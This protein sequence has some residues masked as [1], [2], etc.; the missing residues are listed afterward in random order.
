MLV[1]VRLVVCALG[2]VALQSAMGQKAEPNTQPYVHRNTFGVFTEYSN[3]SSHMLMGVAENRK[4][5][6]LGG[7]YAFRVLSTRF[8]TLQYLGEIR[9]VMYT[10]DPVQVTT[11][12]FATPAGIGPFVSSYAIT[13][14]C[15]AQAEFFR[16]GPITPIESGTIT[17][18]C[19][20]R[21]TYATGMNP[22][23]FKVNLMPHH[24]LQPIISGGLGYMFSTQPI[25]IPQAGSFNFAFEFGGGL[26]LFRAHGRAMTLEYH[27]HHYSNKYTATVNPGVDNGLFKLTYTFG[28]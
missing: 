16:V 22:L 12:V 2:L 7:S 26:E 28:R 11:Q 19:S 20:R 18:T 10:S 8:G 17:N 21:W 13:D 4:L 6:T 27:F 3:D 14:H 23:G 5:I 1:K 9:P 25:P 15:V 24:R